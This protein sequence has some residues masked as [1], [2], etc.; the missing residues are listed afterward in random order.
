MQRQK[1]KPA[2][3]EMLRMNDGRQLWMRPIQPADE[4]PL[5]RGFA[6]LDPEEIR[7]R[8]LHP[9]KE[10]SATMAHD[11]C[12]IDPKSQFALVAAEPL[13][14]G[15][16][17]IGAVA[18][19]AIEKNGRAEFAILVARLLAGQGLG[20]LMMKQVISWARRKRIDVLY[21]DVLDENS[22]MLNLAAE[23]GFSRHHQ[24]DDRG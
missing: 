10:L 11:L 13:P 7:M 15:E 24:A 23:L 1:L 18:R 16:A 12:N 3:E 19:C 6:L 2:W 9:M 8:F 5:R 21:G 14:P 20:Q 4:E 17:L 22:A